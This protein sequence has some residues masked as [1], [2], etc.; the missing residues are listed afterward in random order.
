MSGTKSH[1]HTLQVKPSKHLAFQEGDA[2]SGGGERDHQRLYMSLL[3]VMQERS[4]LAVCTW[5]Q[6]RRSAPR[7]I[8]LV[9]QD[10]QYDEH[11]IQVGKSDKTLR[12]GRL[13][14][15]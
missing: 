4:L 9:P 10:A 12:L 11:N 8:A 7:L 14:T 13:D 2:S 5:K 6:S 1:V 3:L 15:S